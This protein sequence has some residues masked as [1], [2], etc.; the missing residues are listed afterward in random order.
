MFHRGR[1]MPRGAPRGGAPRGGAPRG[2]LGRGGA[3]RGAP[4]GRGGPPTTPSR[5]GTAPRSRPPTPGSSR[6]LPAQALSHQQHQLP[7]P[8]SSQP[9]G[10]GYDEYVSNTPKSCLSHHKNNLS[11]PRFIFFFTKLFPL[12]PAYEESYPE[13]AYES[14][15]SYYSQQPAPA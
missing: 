8:P 12:Q 1:G 6:M 10:E 14:Y 4:A 5:G 11:H 2:A 9:K 3:P 7:L 13:P 15:D